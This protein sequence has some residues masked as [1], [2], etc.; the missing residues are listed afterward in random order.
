LDLPHH[1]DLD[2]ASR[3]VSEL[4]NGDVPDYVAVDARLAW[5]PSDQLE[6]AVVG[7][8]L[9]DDRHPEFRGGGGGANQH[10]VQRSVFGM[11]TYKW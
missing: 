7:R 3:Y 1:V 10:E 8:N 4:S 11:L 6:L 2:I 5:R 9:F